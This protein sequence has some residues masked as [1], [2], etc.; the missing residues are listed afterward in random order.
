MANKDTKFFTYKGLPLVRKGNQI[1]YGN[2]YDEYVV[3]IEIKSTEKVGDLD[4][5]N[6]VM[7]RKMATDTTLPP[8]ELIVKTAK[9]SSLYE[10]LDIAT[11]WLKVG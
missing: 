1:Y 4:V 3:L 5:A 9:K 7:I 8:N 11:A 10:A 6:E 2:M